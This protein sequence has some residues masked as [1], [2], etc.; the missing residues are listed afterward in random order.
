MP[1]SG[2]MLRWADLLNGHRSNERAGEIW[3]RSLGRPPGRSARHHFVPFH[4]S[5]MPT[6]RPGG[7]FRKSYFRMRD[8]PN[9]IQAAAFWDIESCAVARNYCTRGLTLR[10]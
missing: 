7:W 2:R 5:D 10:P 4:M 1:R 3:R 6:I 9:I 8:P